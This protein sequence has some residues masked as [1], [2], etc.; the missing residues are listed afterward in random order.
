MHPLLIKIL[1]FRVVDCNTRL[2]CDNEKIKIG[3]GFEQ[4]YALD[5]TC[6]LQ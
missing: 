1:E 5:Y 3:D 6:V 4:F 2:V